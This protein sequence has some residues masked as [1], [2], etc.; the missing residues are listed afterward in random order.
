MEV[1]AERVEEEFG[2][3]YNSYR[4]R[5]SVPGFRKGKAPLSVLQARFGPKIESE[6][7]GKLLPLAYKE[8]TQQEQLTPIASPQVSEVEFKRGEPLRFKAVVEVKPE[9]Q[10]GDYRGLRVTKRLRAITDKDVAEAL[11]NLRWERAILTPVD[12][13]AEKGDLLNIGLREEGGA[14]EELEVDLGEGKLLPQ[15][16]S[17]LVGMTKGEERE[18]DVDYPATYPDARYRGR[19]VRFL[20]RVMEVKERKLPELDEEFLAEVG[21][22]RNLEELQERIRADLQAQAEVAAQKELKEEILDRLIEGASLEVPEPMVKTY[23]DYLVNQAKKGNKSVDEEEIRER[24]RPQAIR[25]IT[26]SLIL[27]EIAKREGIETSPE[28]VRERV[29]GVARR[30]NMGEDEAKDWLVKTDQMKGLV[31]GLREEKVFDFLI[32]EGKITTVTI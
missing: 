11:A 25:E 16:E 4:K 10:L 32:S 13:G 26:A 18:V 9:P 30:Y 24:Y 20:V 6:V 8:A 21:N 1:P 27:E 31:Q 7:L 29:K 17:Q 3:V 28:E 19:R 22:F 2:S 15:F 23:L 14:E 12:R 5:L